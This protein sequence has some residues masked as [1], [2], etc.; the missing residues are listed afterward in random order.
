V[1][2]LLV[3]GI[4]IAPLAHRLLHRLNLDDKEK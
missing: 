2:F 1:A 4:I 3:V